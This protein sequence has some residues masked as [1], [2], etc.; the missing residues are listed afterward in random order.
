MENLLRLSAKINKVLGIFIILLSIL[1]FFVDASKGGMQNQVAVAV[2][3]LLAILVLLTTFFANRSLAVDIEEDDK[4]LSRR[5]MRAGTVIA[6]VL[7]VLSIIGVALG[8]STG[9]ISYLYI[10]I[11][12]AMGFYCYCMWCLRP[13]KEEKKIEF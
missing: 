8:V 9:T 2:S 6:I 1:S 12:P 7:L 4:F 5:L 3:L 10:L 13:P 11:I